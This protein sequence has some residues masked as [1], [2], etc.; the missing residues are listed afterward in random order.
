MMKRLFII[1]SSLSL[2][3][4]VV[5][6][7]LCLDGNEL[8]DM[9]KAYDKS[10][11][12]GGE[13]VSSWEVGYYLGYVDAMGGAFYTYNIL[14][15]NF[16]DTNINVPWDKL[17]KGQVCDMFGKY[18]ENNPDIRHKPGSELFLNCLIKNYT[19]WER[20]YDF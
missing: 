16:I 4:C 1:F 2:V 11:N 17:S 8:Y 9:Y 14:N 13:N 15:H 12:H 20:V 3:L 6:N 5:N 18:L 19:E 7:G 10:A